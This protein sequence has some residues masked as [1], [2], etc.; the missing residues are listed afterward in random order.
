MHLAQEHNAVSLVRLEHTA[1][2][3]RVKHSTTEPL[4]SHKSCMVAYL[5]HLHEVM[6]SLGAE[7]LLE[8]NEKIS[9]FR[10]TIMKF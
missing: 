6:M 8:P 7:F 4:R 2:R 3:S 5:S 10:V 1:P 9:V